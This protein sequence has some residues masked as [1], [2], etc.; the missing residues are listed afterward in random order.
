MVHDLGKLGKEAGQREIELE[1]MVIMWSMESRNKKRGG[2]DG[3]KLNDKCFQ[4]TI[5]ASD[6]I[7]GQKKVRLN[8]VMLRYVNPAKR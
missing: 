4:R 5:K 7:H 8:K 1:M 6:K 2:E 3:R